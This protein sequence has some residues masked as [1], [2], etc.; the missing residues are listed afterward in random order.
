MRI[1]LQ[2]FIGI[3]LTVFTLGILVFAG[4]NENNRMQVWSEEAQARSIEQGAA[5]FESACSGCHGPQGLGVPGLC[6]PLNDKNF[7]TNRLKEVGWNGS[8]E[9]YIISTV[10]AG[11]LAST[12]PDQYLGAGAGKMAMPSWSE[13]YGGPLRPDQIQNLAAFIMNWESEAL[14]RPDV[15]PSPIIGVGTDITV[16]LPEGDAARG[17]A[18]VA[19]QG[20]VGC[21]IAQPIGPAWMPTANQPGIGDRAE[22]RYQQPDYTGTATSAQQYLLESIVLPNAFVVEGFPADVMPQTYGANLTDQQAAD[23]IAYLQTIK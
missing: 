19:A 14:A 21:H 18:L 2:I 7:F 22:T 10:S 4:I 17:E 6:P 20:C 15:T 1:Q 23:I 9:D 13:A 3:L 11:R 16:Q 8:L 5:M 12:R